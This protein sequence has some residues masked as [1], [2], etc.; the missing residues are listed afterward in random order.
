M[1]ATGAVA[2]LGPAFDLWLL[3]G[4]PVGE[5]L[6]PG[7][8]PVLLPTAAVAVLVCAGVVLEAAVSGRRQ[9]TTE[10]RAGDRR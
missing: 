7:V 4:A 5:R 10:L 3:V 1:V 8:L 6:T 9:I 2:L